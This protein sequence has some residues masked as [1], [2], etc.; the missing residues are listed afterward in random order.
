LTVDPQSQDVNKKYGEINESNDIEESRSHD[1]RTGILDQHHH[2]KSKSCTEQMAPYVLMIALGIH[3]MFEGL[4]V[5]INPEA[6]K[7]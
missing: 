4:A 5:G 3:A 6:E 1:K 7:I 2:G